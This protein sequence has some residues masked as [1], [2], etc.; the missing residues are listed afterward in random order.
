MDERV[1][2]VECGKPIAAKLAAKRNGLC[3]QCSLKR[4][5]FFVL[6]MSLVERV[7]GSPNGYETLSEA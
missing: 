6:G 5:L 2:C 4:N 1:A 7:C 3:L